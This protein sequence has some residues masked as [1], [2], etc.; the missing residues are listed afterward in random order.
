MYNTTHP[1]GLSS[2]RAPAVPAFSSNNCPACTATYLFGTERDPL[3]ASRSTPESVGHLRG[4]SAVQNCHRAIL[5][6]LVPQP[7]KVRLKRSFAVD[8]DYP[9]LGW[10]ASPGA[11]NRLVS[12]AAR[13]LNHAITP[14]SPKLAIPAA[15]ARQLV[16]RQSPRLVP[17]SST[18]GVIGALVVGRCPAQALLY[19]RPGLG[20][21]SAPATRL[22]N[23]SR[24][25]SH[26]SAIARASRFKPL[27]AR[28]L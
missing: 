1:W 14:G 9:A 22:A 7:A 24:C 5:S 4:R 21:V 3:T 8:I 16:R 20:A 13:G 25:A 12:S 6:T 23:S 2:G 15:P 28:E 19:A 26:S 10:P 17:T 27:S 18:R 11:C